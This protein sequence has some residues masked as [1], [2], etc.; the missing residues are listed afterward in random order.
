MII[1]K[2]VE[3]NLPHSPYSVSHILLEYHT[4]DFN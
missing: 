1:F 3:R 2:K 4:E